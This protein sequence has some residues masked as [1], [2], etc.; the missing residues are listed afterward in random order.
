MPCRM[1]RRCDENAAAG[2]EAS[3]HEPRI[4]DQ[5]V[6]YHGIETVRGGID[7]P[8]VESECQPDPRVL[9]EERVKRR[10]EVHAAQT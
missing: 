8:V 3:A 1:A 10:S 2:G 5:P 7:P 9:R 6:P 4:D